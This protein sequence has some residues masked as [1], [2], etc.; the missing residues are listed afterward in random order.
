MP[1]ITARWN[2]NWTAETI[3]AALVEILDTQAGKVHSPTGAVRSCLA[4]ILNR[5]DELRDDAACA[6]A[7]EALEAD[8][9]EDWAR[10]ILEDKVREVHERERLVSEHPVLAAQIREGIAEAERG[11]TR[12]LGSFADY[13]PEDGHGLPFED[14]E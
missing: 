11:E 9:G 2:S 4:D 8:A 3:P 10:L 14:G 7:E 13:L 6:L 12:D 1:E 5:Y